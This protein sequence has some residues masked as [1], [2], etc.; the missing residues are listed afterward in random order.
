MYP[1]S[2]SLGPSSF[3]S[4]QASERFSWEGDSDGFP[5]SAVASA[6]AHAG[7]DGGLAEL[8]QHPTIVRVW[9]KHWIRGAQ[10]RGRAGG[11]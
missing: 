3:R 4:L 5:D 7:D 9:L 6:S 1:T 11:S 8:G 2:F 10:P